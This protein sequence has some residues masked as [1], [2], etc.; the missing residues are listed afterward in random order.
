MKKGYAI[1]SIIILSGLSGFCQ[2]TNTAQDTIIRVESGVSAYL[3]DVAFADQ[4]TGIIVGDSGRILRSTDG[5][6]SWNIINPPK[7]VWYTAVQFASSSVGYIVGDSGTVLKTT[8]AGASWVE[9]DIPSDAL[10]GSISFVDPDHGYVGGGSSHNIYKTRDGGSSWTIISLAEKFSTSLVFTDTAT[11]YVMTTFLWLGRPCWPIN[12]T[13][14]G[15]QTFTNMSCADM[16][17]TRLVP[18][19]GTTTFAISGAATYKVEDGVISGVVSDIRGINDL[20]F[21]NSNSAYAVGDS[22]LR[23]DNGGNTWSGLAQEAPYLNAV[24]SISSRE[25][26]AVGPEGVIVRIT[27]TDTGLDIDE[28]TALDFTGAASASSDIKIYPN[29]FADSFY[30][31]F[32]SKD[33]RTITIYNN[34]GQELRSVSVTGSQ[35][36]I[37]T[38]EWPSGI[39]YMNVYTT[40]GKT[41]HKIIKE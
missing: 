7:K 19:Y 37:S 4:N 36:F 12:K 26:I 23:S 39:Y 11:G 1:L 33:S 27:T 34:V 10:L 29:P 2:S 41:T 13:T 8:N 6:R 5:G 25:A 17:V 35:E 9:L 22:I 20:S 24:Y 40:K 18:G 31:N 14:D 28:V 21:S 38:R 16:S 3:S 15:A 32:A 30:L